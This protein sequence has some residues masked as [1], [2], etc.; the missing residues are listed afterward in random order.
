MVTVSEKQP[1]PGC[2]QW[3]MCVLVLQPASIPIAKLLGRYTG[4][5][6]KWLQ[7]WD[8]FLRFLS[9]EIP[10]EENAILFYIHT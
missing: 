5:L 10:N 4:F 9:I 2:L 1:A 8:T 3:G 7:D 6:T